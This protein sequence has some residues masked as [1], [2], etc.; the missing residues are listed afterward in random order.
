MTSWFFWPLCSLLS[1][2][3]SFSFTM[4]LVETGLH[5][6]PRQVGI[7][8]LHIRGLTLLFFHYRVET[9]HHREPRQVFIDVETSMNIFSLF[10]EVFLKGKCPFNIIWHFLW[11]LI[12]NSLYWIE[13]FLAKGVDRNKFCLN[14]DFKAIQRLKNQGCFIFDGLEARGIEDK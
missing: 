11:R 2:L 7:K 5:R 3:K 6:G 14:S 4:Y 10:V 13:D 1:Q 12:R 8:F 9:G